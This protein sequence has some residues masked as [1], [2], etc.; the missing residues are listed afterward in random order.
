MTRARG[1]DW[2]R[3]T[4]SISG[5]NIVRI[6]DFVI[7]AFDE[8]DVRYRARHNLDDTV[9]QARCLKWQRGVIRR[10]A[11]LRDTMQRSDLRELVGKLMF[12]DLGIVC[13]LGTQPIAIR[14]AKETAEA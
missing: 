9:C 4:L 7:I 11:R 13:Y 2:H 12:G 8:G 5:T 1:H 6:A 14:Q 3:A 10:W